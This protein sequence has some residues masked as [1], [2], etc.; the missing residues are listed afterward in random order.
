MR[1]GFFYE[2]SNYGTY[3]RLTDDG[4]T[5]WHPAFLEL[6]KT[7]DECVQ[8][9]RGFCRRYK[10]KKK[11]ASKP[12]WGSKLLAG[13]NVA[14]PKKD[15]QQSE[16]QLTLWENAGN[17]ECQVVGLGDGVAQKFTQANRTMAK[18][19]PDGYITY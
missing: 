14:P 6:G 4:L 9:Y 13:I 10:P 18:N 11:L 16:T 15:K 2:F 3:E 1:Q 19:A 12:R 8:K 5:Q 7:L 17:A